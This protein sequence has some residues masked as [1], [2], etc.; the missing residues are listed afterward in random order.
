MSAA[1]VIFLLDYLFLII[2]KILEKRQNNEKQETTK[3]N[4]HFE[5]KNLTTIGK[6]QFGIVFSVKNQNLAVKTV[7]PEKNM[8]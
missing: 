7:N 2:N 8:E 4:Y 5:Q 1:P 3:I 6:G